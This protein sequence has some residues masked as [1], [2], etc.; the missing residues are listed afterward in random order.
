MLRLLFICAL[1]ALLSAGLGGSG[2]APRVAS[3]VA[4]WGMG[5]HVPDPAVEFWDDDQDDSPPADSGAP[6]DDP[7][8]AWL[9]ELTL[10][11]SPGAAQPQPAPGVRA[12]LGPARGHARGTEHPPEFA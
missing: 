8:G 3:P 12:A 1:S 7:D 11:S 4:T 6:G 10:P 2:R 5:Q 9:A